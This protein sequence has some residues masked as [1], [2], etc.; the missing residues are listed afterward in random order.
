MAPMVLTKLYTLCLNGKGMTA[1][2]AGE[3]ILERAYGKAVQPVSGEKG[4]PLDEALGKAAAALV[5]A[6]IEAKR[7]RDREPAALPAGA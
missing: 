5:D 3:I 1:V 4:V 7:Q 6:A 2:R